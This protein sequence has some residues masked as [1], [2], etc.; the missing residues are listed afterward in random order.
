[1]NYPDV[2]DFWFNQLSTDDWFSKNELLDLK[3]VEKFIVIHSQAVAGELYE[4]R[5]DPLGRLAEIILID[6]FSRNIYRDDPKAYASDGM[7]LALA[8]EA[9]RGNHHRELSPKYKQFL[10]MPFMHSESRVIHEIAVKLFS[11]EGLEKNLPFELEHKKIIDLYGRYPERNK[12]LGR[13][14][15]SDEEYYLMTKETYQIQ[16]EQAFHDFQRH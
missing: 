2:L 6:Q 16:K 10:Y 4:W 9:I 12:V 1:V 11:E 5:A 7:A 13:Q 15:T 3:M 8:Q 14:N